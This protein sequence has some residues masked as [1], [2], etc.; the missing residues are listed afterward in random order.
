MRMRLQNIARHAHRI[1]Q[2][3]I[4]VVER[5]AFDDVRNHAVICAFGI[6]LGV[7][8]HCQTSGALDGAA[9]DLSIGEHELAHLVDAVQM[10]A[11][12]RRRNSRDFALRGCLS[13][14]HGRSDGFNGKL[15][16]LN[17]A[18]MDAFCAHLA[19][20]QHGKFAVGKRF[21]HGNGNLA[22]ADIQSCNC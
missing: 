10:L 12:E 2:H 9:V 4:V 6:D 8:S 15:D 21:A 22:C 20:A 13:L 18:R 7:K 17:A 5:I 14:R 16:I 19:K 11:G 3:G 1:L